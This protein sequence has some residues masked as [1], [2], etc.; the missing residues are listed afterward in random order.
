MKR[1]QFY[2]DRG[3]TFTDIVAR[4]PDGQL[5]VRKLLSVHPGR[6]QDAAL[7]GI[8]ELLQL[9]GDEPIPASAIE[10]IKMGTT[11]AT[12]ALLERKGDRTL[13]LVT[14]GFADA[15]RIGYQNRP[16]IFAR[17]IQLPQMLYERVV[18]VQERLA[19]DG[20]VIRPLDATRL[21]AD[22]AA[23]RAA[24]LASC[25]IVLMHGYRHP[26][27]E[28]QVARLAHAA[29]FTQVSVSHELSPL[30]K[31]VARGDTTV[32]DAYLAPGLARYLDDVSARL[33][34]APLLMMQSHGGLTPAARLHAKDAL[35][36]GPAGGLVGAIETSRR[37][38]CE[39][40]IAFDMGGTSTDVSH[41][42]G[43]LERTHDAVIAG[44]RLRAPMLHIHT[45]AA[46]GGSILRYEGLKF[47]VGPESAGAL[48]GPACYGRGGPLTVTD[49]NL[50][51]GRLD[52]RFFPPVSGPGGDQPLDAG[53]VAGLF[54]T[55]AAAINAA[56]GSHLAPEAVA[57]GF[58]EI[59]VLNM[60]NAIREIST[61][62]GHD[63]GGYA[64]CAFGGASGQH[65]CRVADALGMRRVLMH[66]LA[67]VLS[68]YGMGLAAIRHMREAPVEAALDAALLTRLQVLR[69]DLAAQLTRRMAADRQHG[70]PALQT[71]LRVRLA[72]TDAPLRLTLDETALRDPAAIAQLFGQAHRQRYG[73]A[74]PARALL[75]EAI[76][77]EAVLAMAAPAEP[78]WPA[79]GATPLAPLAETLLYAGGRHHVAP[80]YAREALC[81]GDVLHGPAIV[82]EAIGTLVIEPGWELRL[83]R[84]G[85]AWLERLA[86][87]ASLAATQLPSPQGSR[88]D[89]VRLEVYGNL[90]MSIAEQ[91]GTILEQTSH[92][93][94]IKERLDFS[95][96]VF[97]RAGQLVANAPHMPVHLGSMGAS[98][99][100]IMRSR[101][102]T[103]AAGDVYMLN[104]PW[105]GGTHLPDITVV[106]PVFLDG[107]PTPGYWVASRAHHADVG[108]I[109]PGSMPPL[110]R[111]IAEEGVLIDDFQL[112]AGGALREAAV[113]GLLASGPYPARN[114]DQNLADLAAQVAAN[115]AGA[116]ELRR[117]S[118]RDGP[119]VVAAY[120][121]HVQDFAEEQVRQAIARLGEGSYECELDNGATIRVAITI[122]RARRQASVDFAGTSGQLADNFNAP[123]SICMAAVLYVF[124]TLIDTGIPIN[125]GCLRPITIRIPAGSMLS[126]RYPAAVVAGN[127]ETSQAIVDA[128]YG[129]LGVMAGSQGTMNNFSFGD[130]QYQYYETL[131]GGTGAGPEFDGASAVHSHMTNSRLTDPE[132][133]EWRFPV[134]LERFG[135]RPG[136]G[137]AGAHRGGDGTRRELRFLRPMMASM[138]ANRRRVPPRGLAG[139]GDALPGH[140]AVL[141]ADG[142][143]RTLHGNESI[144]LAAGDVMLIETPGGGGYGPPVAD[145]PLVGPAA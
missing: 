50:M 37:A 47:G 129:A 133:L 3:G 70:A 126:P 62:R 24:G 5:V 64:L 45:I 76:E 143:L 77:V 135:I 15:L 132:V 81:V 61:Q 41:Y 54:T 134:R 80:V 83:A 46:G 9:G 123:A 23:A 7:A 97:D 63:L 136:S 86:P 125:A 40:I 53:A 18:E 121:G 141:R 30:M 119:Q 137:G 4:R 71:T 26:A 107:Q 55:L 14:A 88:R 52:A 113:R 87:S 144:A 39:H 72:G 112:V 68:A 19:A 122:D 48:P 35:L 106:T 127:V 57:D 66:P 32:V 111:S 116:G 75:I 104:A 12:N 51:T 130:A 33:E 22:L 25:A 102:A 131:C 145:A 16:D 38:G 92:S 28:Q 13:L 58:L 65:A 100:A 95:C 60:S 43:T 99:A 74:A 118:A 6:Y 109:T 128:L 105:N 73:F 67:G 79:R 2:I 1:W 142:S 84:S 44:V 11:V 17:R 114:I 20:E 110:S 91:M 139:G 36:S 138:L 103:V 27:H 82:T 96:A 29:G 90:F 34:G 42:A 85:E 8:R 117:I 140:D 98:V 49:A 69:A 21:A 120:M 59:A 10:A 108:G 101:L 56:E 94:N 124:R 31:F 115:E 78:A 93:V 89:P